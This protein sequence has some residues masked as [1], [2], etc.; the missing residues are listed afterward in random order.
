MKNRL[1]KFQPTDTCGDRVIALNS[2]KSKEIDL[3]SDMKTST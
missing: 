2:R 1:P 3:F